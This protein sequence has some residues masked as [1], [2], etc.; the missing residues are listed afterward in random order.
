MY[1]WTSTEPDTGLADKPGEFSLFLFVQRTNHGTKIVSKLVKVKELISNMGWSRSHV[2]RFEFNAC[3]SIPGTPFL[4]MS[5]GLGLVA[6]N[7]AGNSAFQMG[8]TAPPR[9]LFTRCTISCSINSIEVW[10]TS[11]G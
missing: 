5:R 11:R 7:S 8:H 3:Y 10:E 6:C 1:C 2:P 9:H 4:Y